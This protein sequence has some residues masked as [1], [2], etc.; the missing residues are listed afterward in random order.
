LTVEKTP[1]KGLLHLGIQAHGDTRGRFFELWNENEF[2]SLNIPIDPKRT[3]VSH[4]FKKGTLRGMHF[5]KAPKGDAKLVR[6]IRGAIFESLIFDPGLKPTRN[7]RLSN[8][9]KI[10]LRRFMCL[11]DSPTGS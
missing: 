1:I 4:N 6:V 3:A 9:T 7:G 2:K 11:R 10:I 8:S 5:Q